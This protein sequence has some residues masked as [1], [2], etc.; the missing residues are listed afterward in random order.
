MTR[1]AFCSCSV[2]SL[3]ILAGCV[4]FLCCRA[5]SFLALPFERPQCW[6]RVSSAWACGVSRGMGCAE[7]LIL[8]FRLLT[9]FPK[10]S[11]IDS[12]LTST[13]DKIVPLSV[14]LES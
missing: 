1:A 8:V 12:L 5:R 3:S 6:N 10:T 4:L 11:G 13:P 2:L 7:C 9:I 14:A